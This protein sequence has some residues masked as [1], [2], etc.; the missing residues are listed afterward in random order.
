MTTLAV[1]EIFGPTFQGEGPSLGKQAMFLR[2]AMC[3]LKCSW[4]DTPY[5][6]DWSRYSKL[7]EVKLRSVADVANTLRSVADYA[8][9]LVITGGE[10][11]LQQKAINELLNS[12]MFDEIEVETNGTVEPRLNAANLSY[13]VSPKLSNSGNL[14]EKTVLNSSYVTMRNARFKFVCQT[15]RDLQEVVEFCNSRHIKRPRVWIMPLG[16]SSWELDN[17]ERQLAELVLDE[18][19]NMTTR[20]HIRYWYNS[21]GH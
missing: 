11:M 14:P 9:L 10:P 16:T 20:Q 13:N 17:N 7:L 3:N 1:S 6:W 18:G 4:C 21:R 19:F 2:L 15:E 8:N 5:T 12:V